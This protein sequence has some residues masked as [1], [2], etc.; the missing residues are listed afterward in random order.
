MTNQDIRETPRGNS[1]QQGTGSGG[2]SGANTPPDRI[3]PDPTLPTKQQDP[4]KATP[5]LTVTAS[6]TNAFRGSFIHVEGVVRVGGTSGDGTIHDLEGLAARRYDARPGTVYL[7]RPDQHVCAR[8]RRYDLA[9]MRAA[10][11]RA[12]CNA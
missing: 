10:I 1:G 5:E 7:L 2:G 11:A 12:T 3:T 4:K 6:D 8:W 9:D